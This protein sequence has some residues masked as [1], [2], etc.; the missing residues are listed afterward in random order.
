[1]QPGHPNK[2]N[3]AS[4]DKR[5]PRLRTDTLPVPAE[6]WAASYADTPAVGTADAEDSS[7]VNGAPYGR[8]RG[9]KR[10]VVPP[11]VR[12][13]PAPTAGD[14]ENK[15]NMRAQGLAAN[16][17]E[18]DGITP[19][20]RTNTAT[21]TA[22]A[23][24]PSAAGVYDLRQYYGG[25]QQ[26]Q[27]PVLPALPVVTPTDVGGVSGGVS[28]YEGGGAGAAELDSQPRPGPPAA[29]K[30]IGRSKTGGKITKSK[31]N[32][33]FL[34]TAGGTKSSSLVVDLPRYYI[35][36]PLYPG[37]LSA[38]PQQAATSAAAMRTLLVTDPPAASASLPAPRASSGT[39]RPPVAPRRSSRSPSPPPSPPPTAAGMAGSAGA[40]GATTTSVPMDVDRGSAP[41]APAG[42]GGSQEAGKGQ[43]KNVYN[44]VKKAVVETAV[45]LTKAIQAMA[46]VMAEMEKEQAA[47]I[48]KLDTLG[49]KQ[50]M[51]YKHMQQMNAGL[52]TKLSAILSNLDKE[53]DVESIGSDGDNAP[54]GGGIRSTAKAHMSR[55]KRMRLNKD[56]GVAGFK[57]MEKVRREFRR[58]LMEH[59][60]RTN[61][62]RLVYPNME[63]TW[64]LLVASAVTALNLTPELAK[65]FLWDYI[66]VPTRGDQTE[67]TFRRA[68]VPLLRVK[69]HLVQTIKERIVL[70]FLRA[71]GLTK[72]DM[73]SI[74]AGEWLNNNAYF[75]SEMGFKAILVAIVEFFTYLGAA[76]RITQGGSIGSG[77]VIDC[78]VGHFCMVSGLVRSYLELVAGLRTT[79]R[80][81][82]GEGMNEYW[83]SEV[84]RADT[85]LAR[86]SEVHNGLRLLDGADAQRANFALSSD[87][88]E[89]NM[90]EEES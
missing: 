82:V 7:T 44:V 59:I 25:S 74:L 68:S 85:L 27:A 34:R 32:R 50:E 89:D 70:A 75:A 9:R 18:Q 90:D 72:A 19:V 3:G 26:L 83:V 17:V 67:A 39:C 6:L 87:S 62:T 22:T 23:A 69:P 5:R 64:D 88:D 14:I 49:G 20:L 81:G 42:G 77:I 11:S 47:V 24:L 54:G 38:T 65:D 66:P 1:M 63:A 31:S 8:P 16:V 84:G 73:T 71:L 15:D 60:A 53:S 43:A 61:T 13:T 28:P 45:P 29:K 12:T 33:A 80:S 35:H 48:A 51:V 40:A 2:D 55:K 41:P 79:R 21:G 4:G 56:K 86:D 46:T 76:D 78:V 10:P 57:N 36:P 37:E 58:R 52:D 30:A